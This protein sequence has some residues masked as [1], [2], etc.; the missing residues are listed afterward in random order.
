MPALEIKLLRS[1]LDKYFLH[2]RRTLEDS[3]KFFLQDT[4]LHRSYLVAAQGEE[5]RGMI[6]FVEESAWMPQAFGIGFISTH[7]EHRE[8]GVARALLNALFE[9]ATKEGKGIVMSAF[10]EK[11]PSAFQLSVGSTAAANPQVPFCQRT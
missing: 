1:D 3:I 7:R 11:C 5:V 6:G 2:G 10:D 8:E 9:L 4:V